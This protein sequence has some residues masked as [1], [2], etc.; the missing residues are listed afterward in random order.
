MSISNGLMHAIIT[1]NIFEIVFEIEIPLV[2]SSGCQYIIVLTDYFSKTI[3]KN[4][5]IF[6]DLICTYVRI[7]EKILSDR[8]QSF[9][10]KVVSHLNILLGIKQTK[11]LKTLVNM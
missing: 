7:P 2:R 6:E 8:S 1:C 5:L 10:G 9:I 11:T 4:K 3:A